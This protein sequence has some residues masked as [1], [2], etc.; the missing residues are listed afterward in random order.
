MACSSWSRRLGEVAVPELLHTL[1]ANAVAPFILCSALRPT[2][3]PRAEHEP[4]GHII[5][6]SALEG[7]FAVGKKVRDLTIELRT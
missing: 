6:V 5:N 7:K 3:A 1:A 2:L 4:F